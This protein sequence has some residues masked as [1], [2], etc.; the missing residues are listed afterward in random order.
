MIKILLTGHLGFIGKHYL[1]YLKTNNYNVITYDIKEDT[2]FPKLTD[3]NW[4]I[5][6]GANS[7]TNETNI[8]KILKTNT[9]FTIDLY[10]NCAK[11]GV[12]LQYA[13]SASVYGNNTTF[14]ESAKV[15]PLTPYAWSK[16]LIERYIKNNPRNIIVQGFRYF[17]VYGKYEDHKIGQ[18]SPYFTFEKQAKETGIIQVF[19]NSHQYKRD[20]VSVDR[21]IDLQMKFLHSIE[22]NGVW[23]IGSGVATSFLEIAENIS[24]KTGA[25]IKFIP[26]PDSIKQNYQKYTCADL[27]LLNNTLHI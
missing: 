21:V 5:H 6:L 19:E 11:Y 2:V 24:K 1:E 7:S 26:I 25:S 17:N 12:N 18:S 3:V 27:T 13:S 9:D 22:T 16:Y 15:D 4:V 23:N 14:C 8:D 20:F 10:E